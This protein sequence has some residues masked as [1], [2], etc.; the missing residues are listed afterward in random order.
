M[1][2]TVM[3]SGHFVLFI[4]TRKAIPSP[5]KLS[6]TSK[7]LDHN[8]CTT[9]V[10][11]GWVKTI[12]L[13]DPSLTAALADTVDH[14]ACFNSSDGTM[15]VIQGIREPVRPMQRNSTHTRT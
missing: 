13:P 12:R 10:N 11:F 7:Y 15:T 2:I 5:K 4:R 1:C 9:S 14:R 8:F 6:C 3:L